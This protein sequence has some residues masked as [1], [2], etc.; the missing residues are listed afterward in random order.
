MPTY[1]CTVPA[2]RLSAEQ[3]ARVAAEITRVHNEVTGAATFF[4]Q[5]I[6]NEVPAGNY[7][8]GGKLLREDQIFIN[9]QIRAGRSAVDRARLMRGILESVAGAAKA[10]RTSVWVYL[11]DLPPRDMIEYGH[12]LPEPGSENEWLNGLPAKDRERM[13]RAGQ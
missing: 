1:I 9:G 4:A 13:T 6:I 10:E 12:V 5:V 8:I 2:G 11:T 3:K 7:F